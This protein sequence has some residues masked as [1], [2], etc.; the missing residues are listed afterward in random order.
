MDVN[1]ACFL[2]SCKGRGAREGGT[3]SLSEEAASCPGEG[4]CRPACQG[5]C[6]RGRYLT[7]KCCT[8]PPDP[9]NESFSLLNFYFTCFFCRWEWSDQWR[10]TH[11]RNPLSHKCHRSQCTESPLPSRTTFLLQHNKVRK[12]VTW[13]KLWLLGTNKNLCSYR[14]VTMRGWLIN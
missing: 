12:C 5:S 3:C 4:C 1:W 7:H 10:T 2:V 9:Q 6:C 8:S 11:P 13:I 14:L